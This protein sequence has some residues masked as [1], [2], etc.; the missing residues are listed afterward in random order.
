MADTGP[1]PIQCVPEN[2][3]AEA[4]MLLRI[5]NCMDNIKNET[6]V[7]F[8]G[9][10]Y[11]QPALT[12]F[13]LELVLK[14]FQSRENNWCIPKRGHDLV[15]LF[16]ALSENCQMALEQAWATREFPRGEMTPIAYLDLSKRENLLN[17]RESSLKEVLKVHRNVFPMWRYGYELHWNLHKRRSGENDGIGCEFGD[18]QPQTAALKDALKTVIAAYYS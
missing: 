8:M 17:P 4:K 5:V 7:E 13:G 18:Y 3:I 16:C 15:N 1:I 10:I 12:A 11:L 9:T 14:A 6:K 2:I